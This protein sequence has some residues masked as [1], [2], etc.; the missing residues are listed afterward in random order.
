MKKVMVLICLV[1]WV[2]G[3]VA[4]G[5]DYI[6]ATVEQVDI[7]PQ[8]YDGQAVLFG[9]VEFFRS[10]NKFT[11]YFS[12]GRYG[13]MVKSDKLYSSMLEE[14]YLNFFVPYNMAVAITNATL[15]EV[16]YNA[17]ILCNISQETS[18]KNG[19]TYKTYWTC[20]ITK[21]EL[22]DET[23]AVTQ[24][25]TDEDTPAITNP[26][27]EERA[28]WD[29]DGDNKLGLAEAIRALQAVTGE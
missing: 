24:T 14:S 20:M 3:G 27:L 25:F 9:N 16:A 28:R 4:W 29:A 2:G 18:V 1:A 23:G 12:D 13:A 7:L 21:L 6:T 10:I 8:N 26:V 5:D 22:I 19:E 17:N 15:E 11:G